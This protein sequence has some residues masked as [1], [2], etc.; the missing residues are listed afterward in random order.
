MRDGVR[1]VVSCG[2]DCDNIEKEKNQNNAKLIN[3]KL[4]RRL[5]R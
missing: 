1:G 3:I 2:V 4:N 5:K